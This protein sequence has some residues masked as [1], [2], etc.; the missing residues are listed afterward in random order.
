MRILFSDQI[1]I[2]AG[3]ARSNASVII[4][5]RCRFPEAEIFLRASRRHYQAMTTSVD[6]E[7]QAILGGI[8]FVEWRGCRLHRFGGKIFGALLRTFGG[9]VDALRMR[10]FARQQRVDLQ[11]HLW[12][13]GQNIAWQRLLS[14]LPGSLAEIF[15]G[16]NHHAPEKRTRLGRLL[17]PLEQRAGN[18]PSRNRSAFVALHGGM[19]E[20]IDQ[21]FG[22]EVA[23]RYQNLW[24]P[25][26][27]GDTRKHNKQGSSIRLGYVSPSHKG[28][29]DFCRF[30]RAFRET[31]ASDHCEIVVVGGYNQALKEMEPTF[32]ELGIEEY[33]RHYL[34][35]EEY[36]QQLDS[37]TY[38]VQLF[39]PSLYRARFS[40]TVY[41][42]IAWAIPGVY[43]GNNYIEWLDREVEGDPG[44]LVDSI[45]EAVETCAGLVLGFSEEAYREQVD[46]VEMCRRQFGVE[47][48]ARQ[49]GDIVERLGLEESREML[50]PS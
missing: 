31:A 17:F 49:F 15:I 27:F 25:I 26:V 10:R 2:A 48:S 11:V 44:W 7:Y 43:L 16:H 24:Y 23:Q 50:S 14:F 13:E 35:D 42:S 38:C 37:L 19:H 29:G 36:C 41:D 34:T 8:H 21:R 28:A 30:V 45:D 5:A 1:A 47:R 39:D 46:A 18:L 20:Y 4:A 6:A 32:R 3:H 9:F 22:Q 33:P 12:A 40:S